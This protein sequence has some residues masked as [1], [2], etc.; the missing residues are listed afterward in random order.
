MTYILYLIMQYNST[1]FT[2]NRGENITPELVVMSY[3]KKFADICY[4]ENDSCHR[5]VQYICIEKTN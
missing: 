1:V 4:M 2:D 5:H 3:L